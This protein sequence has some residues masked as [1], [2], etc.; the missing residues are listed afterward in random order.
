MSKPLIDRIPF[1]KITLVL[2]V[3]FGIGL[4]LCGVT[5]IAATG[6]SHNDTVIQFQFLGYCGVAILGLSALG[7]ILTLIAYIVLSIATRIS[8]K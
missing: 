2:A 7:L 5:A 3:A 1:S 6:S 4:G 8:H